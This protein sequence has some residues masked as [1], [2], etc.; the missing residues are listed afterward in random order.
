MTAIAEQSTATFDVSKWRDEY[1]TLRREVHG[2]PLVYLD[3]AATSQK[4]Q[5]V[6]DVI[7]R[8]YE[9]YNSNVHRGV[10]T[11]SQE[12]TQDY[13]NARLK[14]Q[15]FINAGYEQEVI[16]TRGTTEGI[17]LIAS[18]YGRSRL[19]PGDEII[20]STMEHHSNIVPWQML[21]EQTGAVLRVIPIDDRGQLDM[22][23]FERLL[24]D[25]TKIVSVVHISN[26]LGTVNPV[27]DII[28]Q[29]HANGAIAIV[30]GA[31][32][33][34]HTPIDVQAL[35]CDF[36]VFS[37]HKMYG[38]TGIGVLYGKRDLLDAMP[39]YQ[40]G[41]DM[42]NSVTFEKT[43][44]NV[45][46]Y[47]FEAGTPNIAGGIGF[48]AAIDYLDEVGVQAVAAHEQAILAY[49]TAALESVTDVRLI[50]T[51]ERKAGVLSFVIDGV[52]PHDAGTILDLEG[53]AVRT[54]HHCA[55]P[56][57]DRFQVPATIRASLA[58]YNTTED[59]DALV[60]ALERVI[61]V[62]K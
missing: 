16:F 62:F 13:E 22:D 3:S 26:A 51:A 34:P 21:C 43:E 27:K 38:P 53:I 48:G 24:T 56:V 20:V 44:Y 36:F 10:H 14:I 6:I 37:A 57:M 45:L 31:Q 28:D 12:A 46:P 41:G 8:Y 1:P 47:K 54:G 18:S 60:K 15:R 29:A 5:R 40:G 52:H 2:K 42:I 23:A 32:S 59:I 7:T 19:Q 33:V 50:G 30:D 4:P 58:L 49:G 17:N 39:P 9:S 25:R 11:L 55:Q 35:D 61:E